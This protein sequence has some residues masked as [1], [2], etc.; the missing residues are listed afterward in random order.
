M[1]TRSFGVGATTGLRAEEFTQNL[2]L[3]H[4]A[5]AVQ[6]VVMTSTTGAVSP[7]SPAGAW[8]TSQAHVMPS[9]AP[10]AVSGRVALARDTNRVRGF[11]P[12]VRETASTASACRPATRSPCQARPSTR[13]SRGAVRSRR[14]RRRRPDPAAVVRTTVSVARRSGTSRTA[15]VTVMPSKAASTSQAPG[16]RVRQSPVTASTGAE[17]QRVRATV[18]DALSHAQRANPAAEGQRPP[19]GSPAG[20][21]A[22]RDGR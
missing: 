15:C 1:S 20:E 11:R 5:H 10:S 6:M 4:R 14:L 13:V 19:A 22:E 2:G 7:R 17:A 18:G 21:R 12:V 9:A 8:S 3:G 16:S